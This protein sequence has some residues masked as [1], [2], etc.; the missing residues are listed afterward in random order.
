MTLLSLLVAGYKTLQKRLD[1]QYTYQSMEHLDERLLVDVG[2]CR[3]GNTIIALPKEEVA[4]SSDKKQVQS[5]PIE[6]T[7]CAEH[8]GQCCL[9]Q[10][11]GG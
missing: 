9:L 2:V 7:G 10:E 11:S 3:K 4:A 1:E 5:T 8:A 6:Q